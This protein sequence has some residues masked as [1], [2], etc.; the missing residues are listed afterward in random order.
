V[1]SSGRLEKALLLLASCLLLRGCDQ[2]NLQQDLWYSLPS[3]TV[4]RQPDI[5]WGPQYPDHPPG[6]DGGPFD[7]TGG[8]GIQKFADQLIG[9]PIAS[10]VAHR[11]DSMRSG[12]D[13]SDFFPAAEIGPGPGMCKA[14]R[15][16]IASSYSRA[17]HNDVKTSDGEWIGDVY[18]VAGSVAPMPEPWPTEYKD[19]LLQACQQR[20]DL[21]MWYSAEASQAYLAASL[22]D[23]VVATARRAGELP[24]VLSCTPYPDDETL[25]PQCEDDVRKS[26][27]SINPRAIIEV[28]KCFEATAVHCLAIQL[29]KTP[30]RQT[31][32]PD[33][34]TLNV[35]FEQEGGLRIREV[36]V[37]DTQLIID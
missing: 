34:W 31:Q 24:F 30:E 14:R 21:D 29:P 7:P 35:Y 6:E 32:I 19:R 9:K 13:L 26:V 27:A 33:R 36:N 16:Q 15:F 25:K 4:D 20:S 17:A 8:L 11:W 1:R 10:F 37:D 22:A 18:A 2:R 3:G 5:F 28:G 12:I 23:A